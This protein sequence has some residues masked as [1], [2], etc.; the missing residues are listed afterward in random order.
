MLS[1]RHILSASVVLSAA[2]VPFVADAA[3]QPDASLVA[4]GQEY[5]AAHSEYLKASDLALAAYYR[6]KENPAVHDIDAEPVYARLT[7]KEEDLAD[8]V[9]TLEK[10]IIALGCPTVAHAKLLA[11]VAENNVDN[12]FGHDAAHAIASFVLNGGLS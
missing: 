9:L 2:A 5:A 12:D 6:A 8:R 3:V 4:L 10:Q 11:R 1:R 7:E